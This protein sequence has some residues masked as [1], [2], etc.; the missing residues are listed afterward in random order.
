VSEMTLVRPLRANPEVLRWSLLDC[1]GLTES[2]LT[3]EQL[4]RRVEQQFGEIQIVKVASY[5][6]L[7]L[8]K[9]GKLLLYVPLRQPRD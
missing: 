2:P 3:T 4:K 5:R 9:D 6:Y 7:E 8:E 1:L